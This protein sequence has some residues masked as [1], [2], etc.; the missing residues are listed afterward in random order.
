MSIEAIIAGMEPIAQ[1]TVQ[2]RI[3]SAALK[4]H[5]IITMSNLTGKSRTEIEQELKE[6]EMEV[7]NE[8]KEELEES[9]K[10]KD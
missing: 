8:M 4:R 9:L 7:L 5:Y 1:Q 10:S 6:F 2:A 3:L